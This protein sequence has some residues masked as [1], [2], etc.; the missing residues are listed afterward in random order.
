[1]LVSWLLLLVAA[2]MLVAHAGGAT[3]RCAVSGMS[4]VTLTLD[5]RWLELV[6]GDASNLAVRNVRV[7][8]RAMFVPMTESPADQFWNVKMADD[9]LTGA[10]QAPPCGVQPRPVVKRLQAPCAWVCMCA[11]VLASDGVFATDCFVRHGR[12]NVDAVRRVACV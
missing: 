2:G 5:D 6:D 1:M 8:S 3:R 4:V 11:P 10:C 12:M 7:S 9:A